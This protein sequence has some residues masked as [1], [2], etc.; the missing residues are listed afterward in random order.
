MKVNQYTVNE[1]GMQQ[2][3]EFLAA[4]HKQGSFSD[5]QIRAWAADAEFQLGEG[6]PPSIEIR[7]SDSVHG[8]TQEFTISDAGIDCETIEIE[9]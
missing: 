6:N 1:N 5:E 9:E 3:S 8:R 2:I 7:S 4:N